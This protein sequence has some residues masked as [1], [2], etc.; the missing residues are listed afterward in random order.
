MDYY[1]ILEHQ[2]FEPLL[3]TKCM[4]GILVW[5]FFF[6]NDSDLWD[7]GDVFSTKWTNTQ[8]R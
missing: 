2:Q 8:C 6:E 3:K 5:Q 4:T 1:Y 7:S